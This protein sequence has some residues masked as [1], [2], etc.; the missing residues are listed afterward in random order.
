[1]YGIQYQ[2]V[3]PAP[4]PV[5]DSSRKGVAFAHF[6]RR[7]A[8]VSEHTFVAADDQLTRSTKEAASCNPK[9]SPATGAALPLKP[10]G[11]QKAEKS[12]SRPCSERSTDR[13]TS[14]CIL[15][16]FTLFIL[17]KHLP[18]PAG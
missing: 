9:S 8:R 12:A 5:K 4:C 11:T 13:Q 14:L 16:V 10:E 1:M 15:Y 18:G 7:P 3:S 17:S 6:C 2:A